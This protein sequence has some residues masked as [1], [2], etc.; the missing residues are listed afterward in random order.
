MHTFASEIRKQENLK[1]H[2]PYE[3][4]HFDVSH[5]ADD[6]SEFRT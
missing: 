2:K 4:D 3:K 6:S 5:V 1:G